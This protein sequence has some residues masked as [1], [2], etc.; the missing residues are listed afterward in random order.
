[1]AK[2]LYAS[3]NSKLGKDIVISSFHRSIH[4]K[5]MSEDVMNKWSLLKRICFQIRVIGVIIDT[6]LAMYIQ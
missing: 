6:K 1:M 4:G 2:I 3:E 5:E